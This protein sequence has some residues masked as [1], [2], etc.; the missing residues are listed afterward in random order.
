L[1]NC[2]KKALLGCFV[3]TTHFPI[4]SASTV[5]VHSTSLV[6]GFTNTWYSVRREW[7]TLPKKDVYK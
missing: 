6:E 7:S 1:G 3:Q 5:V 4:A 2:S